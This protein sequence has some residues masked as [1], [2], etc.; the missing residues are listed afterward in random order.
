LFLDM[1]LKIWM[2]EDENDPRIIKR[3]EALK[4]RV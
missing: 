3:D 2:P 4:K 1:D